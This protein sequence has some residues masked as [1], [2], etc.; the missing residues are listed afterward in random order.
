MPALHL[1]PNLTLPALH[2]LATYIIAMMV[3]QV[4][5]WATTGE[6]TGATK[7]AATGRA[8]REL[9][10]AGS[11]RPVSA[12]GPFSTFALMPITMV[13][14]VETHPRPSPPLESPQNR[15]QPT[16]DNTCSARY[17]A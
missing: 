11:M 16:S 5:T 13:T 17:S 1:P 9:T 6:T 8:W 3:M 14:K 2:S 12:I 7:E 4:S 10:S 15:L